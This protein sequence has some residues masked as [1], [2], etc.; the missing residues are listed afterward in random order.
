M[1]R[2]SI[3]ILLL[4]FLC[5]GCGEDTSTK[6]E[7]PTQAP[8]ETPVPT[9]T[10]APT[11]TPTPTATPVP[12]ETPTPTEAVF[13][14]WDTSNVDTSWI[15]P[16][17]KLVAFTF[18]DGPTQYYD[19][20]LDILEEN[21]MHATFFV[22]G[23]KYNSTYEAVV[24]RVV[25]QG[26]ELGN[27]TWTHPHLKTLDEAKITEEVEKVRALLE[28]LTGI[29]NFL[30]RPPYG[31]ADMKVQMAIN[32]PLI[33]WSVD[34]ADWNN[35]S[36][37]SVYTRV[38]SNLKD[39]DVVLMHASYKYTMEAVKTMIPELIADGYQIVSVSELAA[40]RGKTLQPMH[41]PYTGIR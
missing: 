39:G 8:T 41:A 32:V 11:E 4:A 36:Y 7:N 10:P 12:T 25:E 23:S 26:C 35:G 5:I 15:D 6:S 1:K 29:K 20:L 31:E 9:D 19:E 13:Q 2:L 22:W 38:M 14:D 40:V 18:D 30:V 28:G 17:K 34:S 16:N 21:G 3:L 33:N 37:D 24:K 27:H